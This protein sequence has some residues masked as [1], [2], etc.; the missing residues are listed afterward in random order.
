MPTKDNQKIQKQTS[1]GCRTIIDRSTN[2][3]TTDQALMTIRINSYCGHVRW[4]N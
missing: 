2:V 1:N 3:Y 4:T